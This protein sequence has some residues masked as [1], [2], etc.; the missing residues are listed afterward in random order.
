MTQLFHV[1]DRVQTTRSHADLACGSIGTIR[2]VFPGAGFYDVR[3]EHKLLP[4]L[5]HCSGLKPAAPAL[6]A[7]EVGG[8]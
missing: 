7:R 1:G 8:K 6:E 3:F 4:R 5:V 2:Q